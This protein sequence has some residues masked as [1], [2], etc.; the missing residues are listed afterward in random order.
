ML[1]HGGGRPPSSR[2]GSVS[3][4]ETYTSSAAYV[5]SAARP[6]RAGASAR[7]DR[8]PRRRGVQTGTMV[9]RMGRAIAE[10]DGGDF[11]ADPAR[12]RRLA[13]AAL[14]SLGPPHE[15]LI[16]AAHEAGWFAA[17]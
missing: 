13:I 5:A 7:S 11:D 4:P 3:A 8:M 17:F 10:A 1:G 15:S 9:D 16:D 2:G 14:E 12:Y 6:A